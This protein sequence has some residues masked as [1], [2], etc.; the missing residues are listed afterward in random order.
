[1]AAPPQTSP[2]IIENRDQLVAW[3]AAG[4]KPADQWRI[5]TEHEK[6]VFRQQPDHAAVAYDGEAGIGALLAGMVCPEW[7][8]V[9]EDGRVIALAGAGAC[10]G[11]SVTL[12][13]G[14]QVE[15]SGAPLDNLHQTCAEVARHLKHVKQAAAPLRLGLIGL[16]FHPT[17]SREDAPWM[18]KGR[19]RIMRDYMPKRGSLGLD[20]MLRTCTIQ[21]N[22]DFGDEADMRLKM[23]AALALQPAATALFANSPFSEGKPNGF[24]SY[25]SWIWT[26]TDPD[27]CGVPGFV[28]EDGFGFEAYVD[29]LLDVPMYFVHRDG[30]YIDASGQSFRAFLEGKLPALPGEKPRISDF[31]DHATTVFPEAR[32]KKY[33]EM[34]GADG[35]PWGRICALPAFWVGLMYDAATLQAA[36]DLVKDWA[37]A[38]HEALRLSAPKL[39]LRAP[40]PGGRVMG[41]L[42]RDLVKLAEQGLHA[43]GKMDAAGSD[44]T[45]Y[46]DV[47]REIATEGRSPADQT[48]ELYERSWRGDPHRI[49]EAFAY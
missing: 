14:G 37:L 27:R 22:L 47:L 40:I 19:Y 32:L 44:E 28:F 4:S 42:C 9:A 45:G 20:M 43:R 48:L 12:E 41:D 46:L 17:L 26:D 33:I 15:L 35:G 34:R 29:W 5:G 31:A 11:G 24:Q 16:G 39:G 7:V 36:W 6:F 38:D 18:P 1:M 25:R 10:E 30:R 2:D 8:P 49:F 23:R 13:P 21:T 3:F